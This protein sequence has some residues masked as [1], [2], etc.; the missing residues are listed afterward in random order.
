MGLEK[1][2]VEQT[3]PQG[4]SFSDFVR[5]IAARASMTVRVVNPEQ[6][7][8]PFDMGDGRSQ[9][10]FVRLLGKTGEGHFIVG[11]FSPT[12][13]L[14][15]GQPLGQKTANDLLRRN[16]TLPHGNWAIVTID[17]EDYLGMFDTHIAS[18]LDPEE[19][20]SSAF[21]L[22]RVADDM[23]KQLGSDSF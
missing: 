11:M 22:S 17:N 14:A 5:N 10:V 15:S 13:K 7:I 18:T 19:F 4:A 2:A 23:E 9:N 12:L 3:A 6:V 20:K 21:T 1:S 16:G 8:V